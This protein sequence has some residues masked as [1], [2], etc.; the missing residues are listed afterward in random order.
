[1]IMTEQKS[2]V[3]IGAGAAGLAAAVK[4][5]QYGIRDIIILEREDT[6]GGILRQCIH[7]GFGIVR[8]NERLSGPEYAERFISKAEELD[9]EIITKA[10]VIDISKD[11]KVTVVTREGL[12][13]YTAK[14][15]V[16]AMGCRERTRGAL[17]IPG[18]R[19]AGIF[20][21]GVM[22]AYVNLYNLM[23]AKNVIILGSGDIGLIMAR[24]LTLEGCKVHAVI[25]KLP[26]PG[27]LPRNVQQCL[28]DFDIPL[29]LNHTVVDIEGDSRVESVTV[30]TLNEGGNV[31]NKSLRKYPCDTLVLSVGL[32]P[33]NEL[34]KLAG[35][36]LDPKTGGPIVDEHYQTSVKGIFAA[37]NVLHVHDLVDYVSIEAEKLASSVARYI[38]AGELQK[39]TIR[40]VTGNGISS[41]VPQRVSGTGDADI[42]IRFSKP[43]RDKNILFKQ[44][45][46]VI[47]KEFRQILNPPEM[48]AVTLEKAA[49]RLICDIEAEVEI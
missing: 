49:F 35:I 24:R 21:A 39:C 42:F 31:I 5:S 32:I 47:Q 1:M 29:Y 20:T 7:D 17:G 25:E 19:T 40:L 26:Y 41:I 36:E 18:V 8:F 38:R 10:A 14:A 3:I 46:N 15:I 13:K 23:P 2:V 48:A 16:L 33:E 30:G 6:P 11:K 45:G 34:S 22:Q 9:I 4:L 43:D 27:G 37:G 28:N 12:K 44:H